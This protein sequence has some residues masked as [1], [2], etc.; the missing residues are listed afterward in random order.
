MIRRM[1]SLGLDWISA[2]LATRI[3]LWPF[4]AVS[5][6]AALVTSA[7]VVRPSIEVWWYS[8]RAPLPADQIPR[9]FRVT[10]G[11][12]PLSV[13]YDLVRFPGQRRDAAVDRLE[14][15]LRWPPSNAPGPGQA[16]GSTGDADVF[17]SLSP[18]D[19]SLDPTRRLGAIYNRLLDPATLNAPQGLTG[20][21][22]VPD[23][24]YVGE[25][26]FYDPASPTS[27]FV[28]CAPPVTDQ[29]GTCLRE[30]RLTE[31]LDIVYRFPRSLLGQWRRL[32]ETISALLA[33]ISAA[34]R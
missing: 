19:D 5:V 22:F 34:D 17:I 16:T 3:P 18:P 21:R 29:P 24:G 4:A 33:A 27:Y 9:P 8:E 15:V 30:I 2:P 10:V 23:S 28:R 1:R 26:L 13:P 14:L 6:L 12:V 31:R 32:D 7:L 25:E 20:R 11:T